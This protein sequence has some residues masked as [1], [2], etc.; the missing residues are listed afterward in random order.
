MIIVV[1]GKIGSG[2][3]TLSKKIAND[4]S[5]KHIN[6][7]LEIKKIY[8]EEKIINQV[9]KLLNLEKI[10]FTQISKIIFNNQEKKKELEQILISRLKEIINDYY[11]NNKNIIIEGYNA[12]KYFEY[13][14]G[15]YL[16]CNY[17]DRKER[18]KE[19]DVRT[20]EEINLIN[21]NQSDIIKLEKNIYFFNNDNYNKIKKLMELYDQN[22]KNS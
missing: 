7:D 21:N 15:I 14:L 5:Y 2:K 3:T 17:D 9:L 20:E 6:C 1:D 18:I 19:R 22:R 16:V 4:Y 12:L 8:Q 13:D 10:D 11:K